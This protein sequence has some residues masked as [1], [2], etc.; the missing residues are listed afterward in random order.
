MKGR[1]SKP[2]HGVAVL[3]QKQR[4]TST[5]LADREGKAAGEGPWLHE[6]C[7]GG[8]LLLEQPPKREK[9]PE[10]LARLELLRRQDEERRYN[11]MVHDVT[12]DVST[13]IRFLH[14]PCRTNAIVH[15]TTHDVSIHNKALTYALKC[16]SSTALHRRAA[17][18]APEVAA[19]SLNLE[20]QL[21]SK[22]C[23]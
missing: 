2:C 12:H 17:D 22:T 5:Y 20:A 3:P 9:N 6:A 18:F 19:L 10:L 13:T 8:G 14:M 21:A 7:Q 4:W 15:D 16:S 23:V 11:A 1:D